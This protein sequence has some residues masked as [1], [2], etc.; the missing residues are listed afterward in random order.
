MWAGAKVYAPGSREILN[1]S[2]YAVGNDGEKEE[3]TPT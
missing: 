3:E 2:L 1:W